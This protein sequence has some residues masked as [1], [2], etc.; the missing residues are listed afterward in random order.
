MCLHDC[1]LQSLLCDVH[2]DGF[3]L[4]IPGGPPGLAVSSDDPST[5]AAGLL[6]GRVDGVA[7]CGYV[8]EHE[9][10]AIV[11]YRGLGSVA[12]GVQSDLV[13]SHQAQIAISCEFL[14]NLCN[15]RRLC[16]GFL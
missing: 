3:P 6:P 1:I 12:A 10:C 4:T 8:R 2:A 11:G 5:V 15:N 7:V 9:I 14:L 16:Q 13:G